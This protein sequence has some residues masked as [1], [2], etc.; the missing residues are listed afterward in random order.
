[1]CFIYEPRFRGVSDYDYDI[2]EILVMYVLYNFST[3]I[4]QYSDESM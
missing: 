1:M 2:E 3:T 4:Y